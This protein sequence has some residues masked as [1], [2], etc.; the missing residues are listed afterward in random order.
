M[1]KKYFQN[2]LLTVFEDYHVRMFKAMSTEDLQVQ[3]QFYEFMLTCVHSFDVVSSPLV[4]QE[5]TS[6][7]GLLKIELLKRARS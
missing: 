2:D 1:S 5:L 6:A 4:L 3:M 7:L